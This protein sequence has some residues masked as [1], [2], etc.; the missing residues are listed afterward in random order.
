MRV[1]VVW[2]DGNQEKISDLTLNGFKD[3]DDILSQIAT[4]LAK[5]SPVEAIN[6]V[7]EVADHVDYDKDLYGAGLGDAQTLFMIMK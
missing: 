5:T 6:A 1:M 7:I 3:Q 2:Y 4:E